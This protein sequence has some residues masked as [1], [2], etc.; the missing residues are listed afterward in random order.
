MMTT[1]IVNVLMAFKLDKQS[2][3]F[4]LRES[5]Y[6]YTRVIFKKTEGNALFVKG[7][8][9]GTAGKGDSMLLHELEVPYT[10][11]QFMNEVMPAVGRSMDFGRFFEGI[12][13]ELI[14]KTV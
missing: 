14:Q 11:S 6:G 4:T 3:A 1:R 5:Y 7:E 10:D 13:L 9:Y 12:Q 2:I 8:L